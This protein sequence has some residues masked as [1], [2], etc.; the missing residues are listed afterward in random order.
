VVEIGKALR[1]VGAD[2]VATGVGLG[3]GLGAEVGIEVAVGLGVGEGDGVGDGAGLGMM[4]PSPWEGSSTFL[5]L[6]SKVRLQPIMSVSGKRATA[7][8]RYDI[9]FFK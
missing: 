2:G 5:T 1:P 9:R 6:L 8:R 3:V 4:L 7:K